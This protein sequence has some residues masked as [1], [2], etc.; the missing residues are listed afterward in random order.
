M[1]ATSHTY[2]ILIGKRS[3]LGG[4]VAWVAELAE[5]VS[6]DGDAVAKVTVHL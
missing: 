1:R 4:V 2:D 5:N 6:D 3:R